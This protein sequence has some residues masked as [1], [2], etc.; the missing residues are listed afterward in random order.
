MQIGI[1]LGGT[2]IA[3]GIISDNNKIVAKREMDIFLVRPE[4]EMKEYLLDNIK[5]LINQVMRDVGAPT[6]IISKI[7]IA[8]PGRVK[9]NIA[10][11]IFNLG[12]TKFELPKILEEHYGVEVNIR[13]DAK[14]A[15]LAEK[16]AGS[17]KDYDDAVFLCLGTGIGGATFV[18]G[19]MLEYTKE[20]GSEYGHMIIQKDGRVCNCGNSGCWEQYASMRAFKEGI[21]E[22]LDLPEDISSEQILNIINNKLNV[23]DP[24]VVD[25]IDNHAEYITTGILNIINIIS[26]DAIA[27][28]GSFV[29]Y[30]KIFLSKVIEKIKDRININQK[31]PRIVLASLKND[32][33]MIGAIM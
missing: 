23:G 32:A 2:H 17:L 5:L 9:E 19:K 15:A 12:I 3:V 6:C 4:S 27:L 21:I 8:I 31:R 26:P 7:G 20:W 10:Y 22:L 28:G 18:N 16:E 33:G 14:C 13:N 11:D 30:D 29:Y 24:I 1:D 25:F